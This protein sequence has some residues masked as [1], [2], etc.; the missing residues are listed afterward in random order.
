MAVELTEENFS[1]H[2]NSNL[3]LVDFWAPWCGPCQMIGPVIDELSKEMKDVKIGKVNVDEN[4][5]L[6]AKYQV[7]G[8]PTLILFSK[9]KIV[10]RR[11]AGTKAALKAWIESHKK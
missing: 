4:D 11:G 7:S 8:I 6:A 5:E 2:I 10:D 9:G 3:A 1:A